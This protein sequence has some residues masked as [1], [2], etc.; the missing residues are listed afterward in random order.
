MVIHHLLEG[1][2]AHISLD[3]GI[4]AAIISP[5][6]AI[7][8]VHNDFNKINTVLKDLITEVRTELF[9]MW[10]L[11]KMLTSLHT[12]KLEKEVAGFSMTIA[13]D[14]AWQVALDYSALNTISAQEKYITERDQKVTAFGKKFLNPNFWQSFLGTIFRLFEFGSISSKIKKLNR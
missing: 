5:G 4:A 2:N 8:D 11:S 6:S 10:P 1:M 12:E 7:N 3:L 9:D 14:A 13:R